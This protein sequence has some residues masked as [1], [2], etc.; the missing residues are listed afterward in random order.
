M[1]RLATLVFLLA[2]APAFAQRTEVALLGGYTTSGNIEKKAVGIQDLQVKGSFTWGVE[3]GHFFS[4]H[5]GAEASWSQQRSG[6][7]IG[8]AAGSADLFDMKLGLLQGSFVYQ[9][10]SLDARIKPFVLASLGATLLSAEGLESETKLS[11][12]LGAGLKWF[13]GRRVGA[14]VQARY[15]PTVL[16]D[17]SSD[18]CDPFGFCQGTLHQFELMGGLVLRF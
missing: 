7:S 2:A 12:A 18:V 1:R 9:F 4:D 15:A 17:S 10:G 13:P 3:L 11:W 16:G 6:L 8:T 5:L 14:R